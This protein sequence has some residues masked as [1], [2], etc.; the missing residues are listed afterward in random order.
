MASLENPAELHHRADG[1]LA[2]IDKVIDAYPEQHR[3][4]TQAKILRGR[5]E[6][7]DAVGAKPNF[8]RN[9]SFLEFI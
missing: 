1:L 9:K 8:S 3:Y 4:V 5:L 2:D 7:L 6:S